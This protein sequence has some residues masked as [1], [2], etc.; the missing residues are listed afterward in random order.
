MLTRV[1]PYL[2]VGLIA[3]FA[4]IPAS[5]RGKIFPFTYT[6]DDLPNGLRLITVPLSNPNVVAHYVVVRTGSRN[7][8]EPGKSGFAHFF[9]HMM[10]RGTDKYSSE[11]YDALMKLIGAETNAFT[12]DDYT[13]YHTLFV[14]EDLEKVAEV[15]AD[16]FQNLKYAEPGFRTEA[17]AVLGEYNKNSA[18]PL[19]KLFEKI[20]ETAFDV[21]TYK[22]TTM[23]FIKDIEAMPEQ[24]DYSRQFFDRYYR[25]ENTVIV[26]AGDVTRTVTLPLVQ[27]YWGAWKRGTFKQEIPA[28]PEQKGPRTTTVEWP[29]PTLSWVAV[30]HKGPAYGDTVKDMP[31]MDLIGSIYFSSSSELYQK[32]VIQEQKVDALFASFGY[33]R[34]PGLLTVLARVKEPADVDEVRRRIL[35][36]LEEAKTKP[37]SPERLSAVRSNLRYSFGLRMDNAESVAQILSDFVQLVPDPESLN[38]LYA[39]YDTIRPEDLTDMAKKYFSENRRTLGTLIYK[40]PAAGM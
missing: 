16:R 27:K 8:V 19:N 29:T 33:Q 21:H 30:S 40:P 26:I 35:A 32:L 14:K 13:C 7:E 25:P 28:E 12:T 5:A 4:A 10:F 18:N 1:V 2:A 11:Q 24:F 23:G 20:Q 9:E 6:I 38:R 39:T 22:H 17:K 37:V 15:E 3:G 31:S 34:D 36:T